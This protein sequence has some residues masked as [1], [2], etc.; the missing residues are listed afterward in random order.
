MRECELKK[1]GDRLVAEIRCE[2]DH[3]TAKGIRE[4]VDAEL[5]MGGVKLLTLDFSSVTFMDSS[6]IGL[7]IG[8]AAKAELHGARVEVIGLGGNLKRIVCMSG[9]ER[10]PNVEIN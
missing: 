9:I 8:R 1:E 7:I 5:L 4:S 2:I 3:H 6:G 10:I